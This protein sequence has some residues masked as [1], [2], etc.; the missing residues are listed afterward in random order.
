MSDEEMPHP[1]D[2]ESVPKDDP[3][4]EKECFDPFEDLDEPMRNP[5]GHTH[6]CE[7]C[8]EP[9]ELLYDERETTETAVVCGH[10]GG[11]NTLRLDTETD[12]SDDGVRNSRGGD[13]A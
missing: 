7:N 10:C 13:E 5:S 12:E 6:Y 8:E 9:L 3:L 11:C 1:D 4:W 2:L